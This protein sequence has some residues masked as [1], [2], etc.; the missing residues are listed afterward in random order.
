MSLCLFVGKKYEPKPYMPPATTPSPVPPSSPTKS[1]KG[2]KGK[3]APT[4]E[5]PPPITV[6]QP[7]P[8]IRLPIAVRWNPRGRHSLTARVQLHLGSTANRNLIM[9]YV[10]YDC[11]V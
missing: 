5:A 2:D 3:G 4:P 1:K 8:E 11:R 10:T 9:S 6:R 7:N